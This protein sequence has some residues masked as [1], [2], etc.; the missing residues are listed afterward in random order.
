MSKSRAVPLVVARVAGW[1]WSALL[2]VATGAVIVALWQLLASTAHSYFFPTPAAIARALGKDW[3]WSGLRQ[4]LLPTIEEL[5]TGVGLGVVVGLLL[6]CV[7]G[8]TGWVRLL[9][10][11]V[12]EFLRTLPAAALLPAGL[13]VLGTGT[14]MR[15]AITAF[16][17]AWP[18]VLNVVDGLDRF[19]QVALATARVYGVGLW[20]RW[21][22]VLLPGIARE[23]FVGLRNAV[24][25]GIIMV[26]ISEMFTSSAGVG[27]FLSQAQQDFDLKGMW[28]GIVVLGLL[29]ILL[30]KLVDW[31]ERAVLRWER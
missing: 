15:V 12:I 25:L 26:V 21:Q 6:G 19:D 16:V 1:R 7:I 13:V 29:G 3:A 30:N 22:S 27:Y 23:L 5:A 8:A 31:G 28:S 24:A 18:V 20:R 10:R 11:A 2:P 17:C 9:S 14:T 4:N